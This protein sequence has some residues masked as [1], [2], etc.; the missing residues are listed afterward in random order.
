MIV[1]MLFHHE[2]QRNMIAAVQAAALYEV[3]HL[4]AERQRLYQRLRHAMEN[5]VFMRLIQ[6]RVFLFQKG[7]QRGQINR[8]LYEGLVVRAMRAK[9]GHE[10]M[11]RICISNERRVKTIADPL[12]LFLH[13]IQS[14]LLRKVRCH[15]HLS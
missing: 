8:F 7:V 10:A 1:K 12:F 11:H 5:G 14:L 15:C 6:P 9:I 2:G 4:R 13:D 3:I